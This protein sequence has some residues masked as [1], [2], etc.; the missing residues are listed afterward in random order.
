MCAARSKPG[1]R[2][3]TSPRRCAPGAGRSHSTLSPASPPVTTSALA[4][5]S[6]C[7]ACAPP[8]ALAALHSTYVAWRD[9][10]SQLPGSE[11]VVSA[12]VSAT[13]PAR[14]A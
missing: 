14:K 11:G 13:P 5:S 7:T 9:S 10:A 8:S 6:T 3:P 4:P 1:L 12:S 2:W